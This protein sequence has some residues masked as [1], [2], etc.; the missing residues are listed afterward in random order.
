MTHNCPWT[1]GQLLALYA[2]AI[3]HGTPKLAA[4]VLAHTQHH[5]ETP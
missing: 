1:L 5:E 4:E 3:V 2:L